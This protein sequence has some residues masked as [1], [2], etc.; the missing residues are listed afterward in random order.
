MQLCA[1]TLC[2]HPLIKILK[3]IGKTKKIIFHALGNKTKSGEG[4]HRLQS[5]VAAG[6]GHRLGM[7]E[8]HIGRCNLFIIVSIFLPFAPQTSPL[9]GGHFW[10]LYLNQPSLPTWPCCNI[11][12]MCS[13]QSSSSSVLPVYFLVID[14]TIS[15]H[16]D[17]SAKRE[18]IFPTTVSPAWHIVGAQ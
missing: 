12:P 7:G 14:S 15:P 4:W 8:E 9:P 5:P 6:R 3:I 1:F 11:T 13:S 10:P 18:Q 17:I 2:K 16:Y